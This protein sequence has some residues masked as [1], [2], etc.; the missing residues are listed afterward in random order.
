MTPVEID[1]ID[2]IPEFPS[3][4]VLPLFLISSLTIV[5]YRKKVWRQLPSLTKFRIL[6]KPLFHFLCCPTLI[7]HEKQCH[8]LQLF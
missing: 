4:I 2:S 7:L 6:A 1:P 3:W 5:A 8:G